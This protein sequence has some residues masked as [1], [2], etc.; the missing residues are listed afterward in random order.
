[1]ISQILFQQIAIMFLIL[2][3]GWALCKR[4]L[5]DPDGARGLSNVLLYL[6]VPCVVMRSY[7]TE[8]SWERLR[9]LGLSAVL[10]VIALA[11][12]FLVSHLVYGTHDRT[13]NFASAFCNAGFIGIPLAQAAFGEEAVFYIAAFTTLLNLLQWTY[14]VWVMTG[15]RKFMAAK[16]VLTNPVT[17]ALAVGLVLFCTGLTPPAVVTRAM[18]AVAALNSPLAMLVLGTSL[19]QADLK[20][21]FTEPGLYR[22]SLVRLV[23]APALTL[24]VFWLLPVGS[25]TLRLVTLIAAC[26]PSGTMSVIFAQKFGCDA[27]LASRAVCL[28]TLLCILTVPLIMALA[29]RLIA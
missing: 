10:A 20:Q 17:I 2:F 29:G 3:C 16:N 13:R 26:T 24:A 1:M 18:D 7:I 6:V 25:P 14:G 5:I 4:G 23:L 12:A 15:E 11:L 21:V 27:P 19:A 28:S 9:D 8:F 22:M